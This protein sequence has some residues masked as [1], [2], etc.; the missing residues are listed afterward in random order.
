MI[1][2]YM[3]STSNL[4]Y[5]LP[6]SGRIVQSLLFRALSNESRDLAKKLHDLSM[7]LELGTPYSVTRLTT[8]REFVKGKYA[9]VPK[10]EEVRATFKLL[11]DEFVEPL[12]D[13]LAKGNLQINGVPVEVC[14]IKIGRKDY[15]RLLIESPVARGVT[16]RL[17]TNTIMSGDFPPPLPDL[18]ERPF[19]AWNSNAPKELHLP[20]VALR[21]LYK[22]TSKD[23]TW[24]KEAVV[25][26]WFGTERVVREGWLGELSYNLR[27]LDAFLGKMASGLM[28]FAEFSGIGRRTTMG[29][30][31]VSVKFHRKGKR[32]KSYAHKESAANVS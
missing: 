20:I 31:V 21:S 16:F 8:A 19:I 18:L 14:E 30:G 7:R 25:E 24:V 1:T 26:M 5:E 22:A 32:R 11:R 4:I 2:A 9:S 27:G 28:R 15:E 10:S 13:G 23:P 17:I 6:S 29:F 12:V 3:I